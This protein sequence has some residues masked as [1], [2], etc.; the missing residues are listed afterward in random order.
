MSVGRHHRRA[1]IDGNPC[2]NLEV[3]RDD[4]RH[5]SNGPDARDASVSLE[6]LT[7]VTKRGPPGGRIPRHAVGQLDN[8]TNRVDDPARVHIGESP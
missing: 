2:K 4:P 5:F 3:R 8:N 7:D 6:G 1:D